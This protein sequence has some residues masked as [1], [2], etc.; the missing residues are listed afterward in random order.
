MLDEKGM[1]VVRKYEV[2]NICDKCMWQICVENIYMANV[3]GKYV[4]CW[5]WMK[6][7]GWAKVGKGRREK[8]QGRQR[9]IDLTVAAVTFAALLFLQ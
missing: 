9:V 1:V 2:A 6:R 7:D 5:C 4:D 8:T 3:C